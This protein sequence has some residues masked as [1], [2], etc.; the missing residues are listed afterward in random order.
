[1]GSSCDLDT[2]LD[3]IAPGTVR[4]GRAAV[5]ELRQV[6][7]TDGGAD[8]DADTTPNTVFARQGIFAP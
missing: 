5:W 6:E 1:M 8:G 4:E 7:V 3:A 2:T